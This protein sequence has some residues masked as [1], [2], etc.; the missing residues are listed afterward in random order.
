MSEPANLSEANAIISKLRQERAILT[1]E[2]EFCKGEMLDL[3]TEEND[4]SEQ[5]I[6]EDFA[7]VLR[8]VDSWL[9]DVSGDQDFD[10]RVHFRQVMSDKKRECGAY[11]HRLG[12]AQELVDL[13]DRENSRV[14]HYAILSLVLIGEVIECVFGLDLKQPE[15]SLDLHIWGLTE[16]QT[17]FLH[18]IQQAMDGR[19]GEGSECIRLS[20]DLG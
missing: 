7:N 14:S 19:A 15:R 9:D 2:L 13:T 16:P 20:F 18:V 10:P 3:L 8:G 17:E 1:Q 11:F 5:E 12:V 4:I 6:R